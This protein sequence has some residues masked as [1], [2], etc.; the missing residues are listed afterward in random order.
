MRHDETVVDPSVPPVEP[1]EP[2]E[3][4]PDPTEPTEPDEDEPAA[5]RYDGGAI[6]R[7]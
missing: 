6:P 2:T 7:Q 3:P 5:S 4:E 1:T